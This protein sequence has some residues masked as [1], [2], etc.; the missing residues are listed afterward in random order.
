MSSNENSKKDAKVDVD[1]NKYAKKPSSSSR[2]HTTVWPLVVL[3]V[4]A[5]LG[6]LYMYGDLETETQ[7]IKVPSQ[8]SSNEEP[9]ETV[10]ESMTKYGRE[11]KD[12]IGVTVD[13]EAAEF[14][15]EAGEDVVN[16]KIVDNK[17]KSANV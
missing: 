5:F 17:D 2:H 14:K 12:E 16:D 15:Q 10:D 8:Q 4:V 3:I 9:I 13:F 6:A 11:D 7:G 1:D